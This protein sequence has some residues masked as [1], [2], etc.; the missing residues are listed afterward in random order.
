MTGKPWTEKYKPQR[1][2]DIIG[3]KIAIQKIES[4][5][6]DWP[7]SALS[8]RRALLLVGPSGVGKTI[9]VYVIADE[10]GYEVTEFNASDKRSKKVMNQLLS[11]VTRSGSLFSTR[12]RVILIDELE[13]LSGISDRGAFSAIKEF[14]QKSNVPII[15]VAIDA[16]DRK[17]TPLRQISQIIEFQ[18][19]IEEDICKLLI[20]ICIKEKITYEEKALEYLARQ[21]KGDIRA[22]INDLQSIAQRGGKVTDEIILQSEMKWRDHSIDIQETLDKIFYAG[23]WREAVNAIYQTDVNPDEL[24]RWVSCNI[25]TVFQGKDQLSS[26]FHFLSRASIFG[27]RIRSTQNWKLLSYYKELM[28]ITGSIIKGTPI[29]R[30]QE[31]RFPEWIKQLGWSRRIRQKRKE[32]GEILAPIVHTSSK[33]AYSEYIGLLQTLLKNNKTKSE[34]IKELDLSEDIVDFILKLKTS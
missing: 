10:L 8:S 15:L 17:I 25:S 20:K 30:R 16:T 18:S 24:L 26:A 32:L 11:N 22:A 31:Y 9:A 2:G 5:L 34:V 14:I 6:T 1:I 28:C 23:E 29:I 3:N 4:W 21:A 27:N 13:G 12:G 19:A 33:I 7:K